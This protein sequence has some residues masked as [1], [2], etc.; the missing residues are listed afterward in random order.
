MCRK[1]YKLIFQ[2]ILLFESYLKLLEVFHTVTTFPQVICYVDLCCFSLHRL[3]V[4]SS[5]SFFLISHYFL[6]QRVSCFFLIKFC[7][8]TINQWIQSWPNHVSGLQVT[9]ISAQ[10][11]GLRQELCGAMAE[12]ESGQASPY[13]VDSRV[14]SREDAVASLTEYLTSHQQLQAIHI[15]RSFRWAESIQ[16]YFSFMTCVVDQK[17]PVLYSCFCI[18]ARTACLQRFKSCQLKI[19]DHMLKRVKESHKSLS[20]IFFIIYPMCKTIS[21]IRLKMFSWS[22]WLMLLLLCILLN[23]VISA[24]ALAPPV[25]PSLVDLPCLGRFLTGSLKGV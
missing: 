2:L 13:N 15:L 1:L 8:E 10:V 20:F 24:V 5:S 9:D 19:A 23:L 7:A 18:W 22:L 14:L 25:H 6:T 4:L 11:T 3:C 16:R 21:Q 17:Y 12:L